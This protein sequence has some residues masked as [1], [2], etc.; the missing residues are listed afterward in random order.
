L[1]AVRL[2]PLARAVEEA[3]ERK[4]LVRF[5]RWRRE[6]VRDRANGDERERYQ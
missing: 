6:L 4:A 1:G 3:R 2:H 5:G